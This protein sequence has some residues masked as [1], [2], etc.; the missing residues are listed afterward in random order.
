LL[1]WF[2][3]F[4]VA[5]FLLVGVPFLWVFYVNFGG[6]L[7]GDLIERPPWSRTVRGIQ[8]GL[9]PVVLYLAWR[10]NFTQFAYGLTAI[11]GALWSFMW[12]R[13]LLRGETWLWQRGGRFSAEW[14]GPIVL[15]GL[16]IGYMSSA[17][18]PW[19]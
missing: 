2:N 12:A 5:L 3:L 15:A 19:F 18:A 8:V 1:D 10:L 11:I 9:M 7:I 6:N 4:L 16:A 17:I 13:A 14:A